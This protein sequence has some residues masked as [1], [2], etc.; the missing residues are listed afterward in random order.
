M[1]SSAEYEPQQLPEWLAALTSLGSER[2]S[3]R[4]LGGS[5]IM[6]I[7]SGLVSAINFGYNV[8]VARL[9]GPAGFG[10]AAVAVTLLMLAS[11]ITLAFQLVCAKF[12]AKND[13]PGGKAGVYSKLMQRAWFVGISVGSVLMIASDTVARYLNLPSPQLVVLLA[14]GVAFYVPLG[15]RRGGLQGICSFRQLTGNFLLEAFVRFLGAIILI[16]I[17]FGVTGAVGAI[18]ASVIL[19]YFLPPTPREL[20]APATSG[21]PASFSE[22]MQAIVFFVGQV[23]INNIDILLV[24][25]FFPSDLAGVYAAVALVGRVLYFF[26]WSVVSAMFPISAGAKHQDESVSV[27]VVP[28][29]LVLVLSVVFTLGLNMFPEL[30]FRAIFGAKINASVQSFDSLLTL[31]AAATGTYSLAVVLMAYEMSRKLANTGW[32]Q[33]AFSGAIVAGIGMFHSTLRQVVIVQLVLMM[34]LLVSASLPF[35]RFGRRG[36]LQAAPVSPTGSLEGLIPPGG[37]DMQPSMKRLRR[38]TEAEVI[39]EFLKNEFYHAEFQRDRDRF[40]RWV[41]NPDV[42]NAAE[43]ALRR[44]LLFRRR[45]TM[46]RELPPD[47]EWFEVEITTA[48]LDRI[49]VFPRA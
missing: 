45:E 32:V 21:L 30:V 9:L 40:V 10:H 33:L 3:S 39:A 49:R 38:V 44:A 29:V 31:Y 22:G 24:K 48:D 15:V 27:I 20:L 46:W 35:F 16:K 37:G 25:H 4:I 11:S 28:L 14:L 17:G 34:M 19:A 41:V 2:A 8:A 26:S 7:G 1:K 13:T 18:A 47:T 5:L 42:S 36:L 6:L 43:N 12:I 23:I